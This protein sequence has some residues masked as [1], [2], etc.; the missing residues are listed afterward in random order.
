[1]NSNIRETGSLELTDLNVNSEKSKVL[2]YLIV[3][4]IIDFILAVILL[5]ISISFKI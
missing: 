2:P 1:M 5:I 4:R 3:K